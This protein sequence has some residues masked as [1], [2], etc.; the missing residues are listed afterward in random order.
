MLK[1]IL[2]GAVSEQFDTFAPL[3]RS[4]AEIRPAKFAG[5]AGVMGAALAASQ[6]L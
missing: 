1:F 3:L 6:L 4:P 2:G 5:Q